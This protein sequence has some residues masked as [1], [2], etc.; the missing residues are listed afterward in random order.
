M[1]N[2]GADVVDDCLHNSI[3]FPAHF[4]AVV[5]SAAVVDVAKNI[6]G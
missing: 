3:V 4:L 5:S 1:Y 2:L 6:V